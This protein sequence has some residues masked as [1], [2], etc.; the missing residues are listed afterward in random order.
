MATT[1]LL[2]SSPSSLLAPLP[3]S[4]ARAQ[5]DDERPA[6]RLHAGYDDARRL[7][8]TGVRDV[9][10]AGLRGEGYP[11]AAPARAARDPAVHFLTALSTVRRS[12]FGPAKRSARPS[13][14]STRARS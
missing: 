7:C 13:A 8:E 4:R 3:S 10:L 12:P 6:R 2:A 14:G 1:D 5:T 11:G 9:P